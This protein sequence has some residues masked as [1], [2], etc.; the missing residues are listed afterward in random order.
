MD[1]TKTGQ[2]KLDGSHRLWR[3]GKLGN[4]ANGA[5]VAGLLYLAD[6]LTGL[7]VTPLPDALE[8]LVLAACGTVVGLITSYVAKHR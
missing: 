7:D 5:V 8:P 2:R 1:E 4:L 6:A 3:D